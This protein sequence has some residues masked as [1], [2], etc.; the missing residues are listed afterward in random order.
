MSQQVKRL[1]LISALHQEQAG[2]IETMEGRE[3][4]VRGMREY[5]VGKL[6]GIDT[7]CVLSRIG[8]VAA[9]ATVA[10]LIEHFGVSHIAFT[11]VA[12]AV[13]REIQIGDIVIADALVQHDIDATPLF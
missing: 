1:G 4:T 11:G 2:L 10:T 3:T 8:K 6:W 5:V 7:V 9:A 12:G 13:D